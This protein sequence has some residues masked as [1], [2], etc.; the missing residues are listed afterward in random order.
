VPDAPGLGIDLDEEAIAAHP[1]WEAYDMQYRLRSP[2]EL[3]LHR[4]DP[5]GQVYYSGLGEERGER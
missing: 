5:A 1:V 2:D 3:Q 4:P